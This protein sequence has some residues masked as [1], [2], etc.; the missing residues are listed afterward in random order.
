[1]NAEEFVL[2]ALAPAGGQTHSPVQAQ[3]LLFLLEQTVAAQ[4]GGPFFDFQ[5]YNYGPFDKLVYEVLDSLAGD[6]L[7]AVESERSWHTFRLTSAGQD[8]GSALLASLPSDV[9]TYIQKVS[10]WV[11]SLSFSQLVS[12]IY[13]AYPEMRV[14]SVFQESA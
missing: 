14:N 3:K 5:P 7:V 12:A 11:R 13:K 9:S 1:M 4:V 6:G 2:A 8:R 10:Q